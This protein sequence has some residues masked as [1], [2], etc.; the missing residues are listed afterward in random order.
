MSDY[1]IYAGHL[2]EFVDEHT[3]GAGGDPYG[4][5]PYCGMEPVMPLVGWGDAT[6][7]DLDEYA[8]SAQ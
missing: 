4:H 2:V 5:E 7:W 8:E 1:G 3:C 6:V